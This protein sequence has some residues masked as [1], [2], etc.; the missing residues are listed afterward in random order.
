MRGLQGPIL[1]VVQLFLMLYCL[2]MSSST[3]QEYGKHVPVLCPGRRRQRF[4]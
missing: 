4:W 2:D 1:K 3:A